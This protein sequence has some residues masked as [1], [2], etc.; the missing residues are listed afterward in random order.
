MP[1]R[2]ASRTSD[3]FHCEA[4]LFPEAVTTLQALQEIVLID[5][6]VSLAPN[7]PRRSELS[8]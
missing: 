1:S 7:V 2:L 8:P 6:L 4:E 5:R 3:R